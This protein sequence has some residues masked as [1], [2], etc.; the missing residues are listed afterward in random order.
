FLGKGDVPE[1][2]PYFQQAL[3]LARH[4]GSDRSEFRA[5]FSLGS[6]ETQQGELDRGLAD[7]SQALQW[8]QQ[9]GYLRETMLGLTLVSRIERD[10]GDYPSALASLKKQ[11]GLAVGQGNQAQ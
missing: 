6:L 7:V 1:A 5:L 2:R 10:K 8:Y 4:Y 11:L 3:E 9:R